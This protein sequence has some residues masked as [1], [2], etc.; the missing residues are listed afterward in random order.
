MIWITVPENYVL[1]IVSVFSFDLLIE[2]FWQIK[3]NTQMCAACT[4]APVE[5]RQAD[6][7]F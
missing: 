4:Q 7:V 3:Y 1:P 5:V 2:F 6:L